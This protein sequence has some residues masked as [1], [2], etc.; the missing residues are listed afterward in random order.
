MQLINDSNSLSDN[1]SGVKSNFFH[2]ELS[3]TCLVVAIL[4][5]ISHYFVRLYIL[6]EYDFYWCIFKVSLYYRIFYKIIIRYFK[7]LF[8]EICKN[9]Q[10]GFEI[11]INDDKERETSHRITDNQKLKN[12]SRPNL[13]ES[14][15]RYCVSSQDL[16]YIYSNL[17]MYILNEIN[18]EKTPVRILF[19]SSFL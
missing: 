16:T 9:R 11:F 13:T 19:N 7:A 15:L 5:I 2:P 14:E 1:K 12:F 6:N 3:F 17:L 4:E 18:E 10:D 8:S